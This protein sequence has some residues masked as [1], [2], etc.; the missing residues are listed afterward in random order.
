L[1]FDGLSF[2]RFGGHATVV[3]SFACIVGG[4]LGALLAA[5]T[6][7]ADWLDIKPD[8]P[9]RKLGVY[10][11]VLNLIATAV[12]AV[13]LLLRWDDF[14]AA[15]RVSVLQLVL[16]ILGVI[17]LAISG[18]LGGRMAYDQ[19][20]GVARMSKDKWRRLAEAGHANLP[21]AKRG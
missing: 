21:P 11:L 18:Y 4:L 9:A 1:L 8:K 13:N 19:G 14:R 3:A 2:T 10:H 20:I 17:I 7:L 6:G 5:P 16:S 12:F 15:D